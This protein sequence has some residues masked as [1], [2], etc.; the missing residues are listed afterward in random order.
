MLFPPLNVENCE[1]SSSGQKKHKWVPTGVVKS[2]P[3]R[4]IGVD[5]LCDVCN[6]RHTEIISQEQYEAWEHLIKEFESE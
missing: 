2:M 4:N 3:G 1:G 6:K 5:F